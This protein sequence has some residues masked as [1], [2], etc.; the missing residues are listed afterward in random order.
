MPRLQEQGEHV[1]RNLLVFAQDHFRIL[2]ENRRR[3]SAEQHQDQHW[4]PIMQC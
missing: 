2:P 3:S 4:H 1:T